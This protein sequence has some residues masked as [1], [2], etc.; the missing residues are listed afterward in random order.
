[1]SRSG[2]LTSTL[3]TAAILLVS[4]C[5]N[6]K[7]WWQNGFE[8]GPEYCEPPASVAP[9]W[10]QADDPRLQST[11]PVLCDWWA[12]FDDP[13]LNSLIET[14]YRENLDLQKAAYR[15]V[16]A[17]ANR[18]MV[19]GQLFPQRQNAVGTYVH[20]QISE[21]LDQGAFPNV[22]NLWLDGLAVSWELDIWGKFRRARESADA[23]LDASID[24]YHDVL[25]LLLAD[26]AT[27]YIQIRTFQQELQ[28]VRQNVAIQRKALELSQS[29]FESGRTSE[30]DVQ[31]A[32]SNLE[33]T[34]ATITPLS[35]GLRQAN[36]RLCILLGVPPEDLLGELGEEPIPR[37][38]AE[39]AVGVPADLLRRR[40]DVRRSERMVA[41]QCAQIGVAEA[42]FY[43][44]FGLFGFLG[45][46]GNQFPDLFQGS[47]YTGIIAPNFSWKILNYGRVRNHVKIEEARLQQ[48]VLDYQQTVLRAGREAE[49]AITA[50]L[51]AQEQIRH[52]DASVKAAERAV[53]LVLG[54]YEEGKTDFTPVSLATDSLARA[55]DLLAEARQELALNL[56]RL[57]KALGGGYEAFSD[58]PTDTPA[59]TTAP[60]WE[61]M[62]GSAEN[63]DAGAPDTPLTV[64][65]PPP[66]AP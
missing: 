59:L 64:D 5:A 54:R 24:T 2:K 16:E 28:N 11:V 63:S 6:L 34:E 50:A 17:H 21:N 37:A 44:G 19:A 56:V 27:N 60:E 43:P 61:A 48:R 32:R 35:T 10:L 20:G 9:N 41:A 57:Y 4:G 52:L 18:N 25:V 47:S 36:N 38:P 51:G 15:I 46:S 8:V 23:E 58:C 7:E 31:Q 49:D 30:Q 45:L 26:V 29:R 22:F 12:T 65:V 13:K 66:S 3:L 62:N 53:S 39:I 42:D 40:P 14:A 55:Q 33:R 1:M